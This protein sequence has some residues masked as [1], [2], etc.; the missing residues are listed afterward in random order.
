MRVKLLM[1]TL[2]G[3]GVKSF[4]QLLCKRRSLEWQICES[5]HLQKGQSLV[6]DRAVD[7]PVNFPV[8]L[9]WRNDTKKEWWM[10][11]LTNGWWMKLMEQKMCKHLWEW[12][13]PAV[14][15]EDWVVFV[16]AQMTGILMHGGLAWHS[17]TKLTIPDERRWT[18]M[19]WLAIMVTNHEHFS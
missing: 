17:N 14:L 4:T 3:S 1:R 19:T 2:N 10:T 8:I 12:W 13:K 9:L 6:K 11:S 15:V 16:K 7:D 5:F 18:L